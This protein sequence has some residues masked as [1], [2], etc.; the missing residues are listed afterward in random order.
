MLRYGFILSFCAFIFAALYFSLGLSVFAYL[1][2]GI[3]T[4]ASLALYI[5]IM[6]DI[7]TLLVRD[8]ELW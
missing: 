1:V 2:I 6:N 7:I 3:G 8:K 4:I 5:S